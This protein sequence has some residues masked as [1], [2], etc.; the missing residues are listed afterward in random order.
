MRISDW[1]S[2]VCSSDLHAWVFD[3]L[4][5]GRDGCWSRERTERAPIG[6]HDVPEGLLPV[7][8]IAGVLEPLRKLVGEKRMRRVRLEDAMQSLLRGGRAV[9]DLGQRRQPCR[10]YAGGTRR[11]LEL[12]DRKRGV[13]GKGGVGTCRS[14]WWR[15]Q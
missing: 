11:F 13:E 9:L 3:R 2:D 10:R 5:L 7:A 8:I 6:L 1:S 4:V 15:R 14:R 12:T